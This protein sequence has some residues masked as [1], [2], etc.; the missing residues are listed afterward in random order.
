[1][2]DCISGGQLTPGLVERRPEYYWSES[3]QLSQ[4]ALPGRHD[5]IMQAW[6]EPGHPAHR[7]ALP[8]QYVNTLAPTDQQP[9][10][11]V[12]IPGHG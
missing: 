1:M 7:E 6:T 3:T 11:E 8:D 9:H 12:W 2:I 10:P 5:M 4:G